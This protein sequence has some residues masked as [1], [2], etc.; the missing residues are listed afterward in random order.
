MGQEINRC[1]FSEEDR[2]RFGERL[3]DETR[4]LEAFSGT[5]ASPVRQAPAAWSWKAGWWTAM[6]TPPRRTKPS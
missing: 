6:P 4:Q 3:D 5:T 1:D 2:K